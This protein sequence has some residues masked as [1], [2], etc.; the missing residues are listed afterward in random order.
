M[1]WC[2]RWTP[3]DTYMEGY[4]TTYKNDVWV[5]VRSVGTC[6]ITPELD[7]SNWTRLQEHVPINP[8]VV[9]PMGPPGPLGPQGTPGKDG[10]S[11]LNDE[12][13][14]LLEELRTNLEVAID[15]YEEVAA[16]LERG[17]PPPAAKRR[18][19]RRG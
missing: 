2:G 6:N 7:P 8:S 18:K 3:G 17:E 15:K 10:F 1:I 13:R 4:V 14:E 5:C 19:P 12:D 16:S 9:G 11:R